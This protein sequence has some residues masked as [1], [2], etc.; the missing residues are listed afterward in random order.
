MPYA[1]TVMRH[2]L[3]S[4]TLIL[5]ATAQE[6]TTPKIH[7]G[8]L[9]A[10]SPLGMAM[11]VNDR[12]ALMIEPQF[13]HRPKNNAEVPSGTTAPD[14]SYLKT[15]FKHQE[16]TI[17]LTWGKCG[18]EGIMAVMTTDKPVELALRM[19]RGWPNFPA[20]WKSVPGGVDGYLVN[21]PDGYLPAS[22][23]T[24]P[25]PIRV[26]GNYAGE[27]NMIVQFDPDKPLR[28]AAGLGELPKFD[29]IAPAL[30]AA[31][32]RYEASRISATGDWGGFPQAISDTL[33]YSR[34]FSNFDKRRAHIVGRGWWIYEHTNHNP[35]MGPYF[36]WDA[37]FNGNLAMLE[38]PE[39]AR[40]TVRGVLAYQLPD[41]FVANYARWDVPQDKERNFC[42]MDRSQPPVGAMSVWKMHEHQPDLD[43][44]A[45]VYP[46]LVL[47][48]QWW[49]KARDGN[50]NGLLEWGSALGR[51]DL[52]RLETGWDDTPHYDGTPMVGSQMAADAVDLNAL[53]SMDNHY[54]SKIAAALGKTDEAAKF[55][56]AHEA[57]NRRINEWLWNEELGLY[58]SRAWQD[59][60]NGRPVF[61]TRITP[62]NFY[63]MICGA[64]DKARGERMLQ[65]F[66]QPE[67]FWG[68]RMI[69]TVPYDDPEWSKQHYWKGHVWAPCNWLVWQGFKRYADAKHR[70]E[71]AR[72][73]VRLF[74]HHWNEGR[75]CYENYRS[76]IVKGGDH[77]NYTWGALLNL[78]AIEAL[79]EVD[80][81]FNPVPYKDSG[82]TE[83]LTLRNIPYGG[84]RYRI[85]VRG[86]EVTAT[87]E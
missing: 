84:K 50:G 72:R 18:P 81:N 44:L 11:V 45:E 17:T 37:F 30:E 6:K 42:S 69:P 31:G 38:D 62:F 5:T 23:R 75:Q 36:C 61:L 40:E 83:N 56:A 85:N 27:V 32:K 12:A 60:P 4:A 28:V 35:D 59:Q 29:R 39:G 34:T 73:S 22:V 1:K 70:A 48:N 7:V 51:Y 43:F 76:D 24:E 2:Y 52:A 77:P 10:T 8:H 14:G 3:L 86:G 13:S 53:W 63:P 64:P 16:A 82:I 67:K 78:I 15:T 79:C 74:M 21:G 33:N 80:E 9:C 25:A 65:Y 41:G 47:W 20:A 71:F 19:Q 55:A 87:Q 46:K 68:E 57:H 58:C 26:D 66:Y 49:P 54:L